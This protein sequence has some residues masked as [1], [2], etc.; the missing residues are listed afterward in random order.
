MLSIQD[1]ETK[2][3]IKVYDTL[4]TKLWGMADIFPYYFDQLNPDEKYNLMEALS[5]VKKELKAEGEI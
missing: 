1:Q 2:E 5:E 3:K 4:N